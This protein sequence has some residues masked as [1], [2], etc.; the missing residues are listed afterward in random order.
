MHALVLL[1]VTV[2][3]AAPARGFGAQ[4]APTSYTFLCMPNPSAPKCWNALDWTIT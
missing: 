4:Q 2:L 1:F 3:D